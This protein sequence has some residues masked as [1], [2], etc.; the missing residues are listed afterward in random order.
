MYNIIHMFY[1]Y[2]CTC[3]PMQRVL[4]CHCYMCTHNSK[5]CFGTDNQ[6]ICFTLLCVHQFCCVILQILTSFKVYSGASTATA[7]KSI[8][9]ARRGR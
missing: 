4:L 5:H 7:I 9:F 8:E 1:L 6:L 2:V 3:L